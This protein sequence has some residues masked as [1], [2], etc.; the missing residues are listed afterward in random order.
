MAL[1]KYIVFPP[2][3]NFSCLLGE[4][5][6]GVG[7][8]VVKEV[9]ELAT[10]VYEE[11]EN[12]LSDDCGK[13]KAVDNLGVAIPNGTGESVRQDEV[14][15]SKQIV[16]VR[17]KVGEQVERFLELSSEEDLPKKKSKGEESREGNM[18]SDEEEDEETVEQVK[19][20]TSS[21]VHLVSAPVKT[22]FDDAQPE[23]P[24]NSVN[25]RVSVLDSEDNRK[26][27]V[28][29]SNLVSTSK[30]GDRETADDVEPVEEKPEAGLRR[31]LTVEV[32][33]K[34]PP[35]GKERKVRGSGDDINLMQESKKVRSIVT[36][37][38]NKVAGARQGGLLTKAKADPRTRIKR[39]SFSKEGYLTIESE[40]EDSVVQSKNKKHS[41]KVQREE[42]SKEEER[43]PSKPKPRAQPASSKNGEKTKTPVRLKPLRVYSSDDVESEDHETSSRVADQDLESEE[44]LP[45]TIVLPSGS[46]AKTGDIVRTSDKAV[47][48]RRRKSDIEEQVVAVK[49]LS[50]QGREPTVA[51][52]RTISVLSPPSAISRG[53]GKKK[54]HHDADEVVAVHRSGKSKSKTQIP[55]SDSESAD[56][57]NEI[58]IS[59]R[60]SGLTKSKSVKA[61]VGQSSLRDVID[62][63]QKPKQQEKRQRRSY[64]ASEL[65]KVSEV[66]RMES[67]DID[68][69]HNLRSSPTSDSGPDMPPRRR[70]AA[71]NALHRLHDTLMPDLVNFEAQMK[72][73]KGRSRQSAGSLTAFAL[74]FEEERRDV[75][76]RKNAAQIEEGGDA[77]DEEVQPRK[78]RRMS[79]ENENIV[80]VKGKL[81]G[82]QKAKEDSV[83]IEGRK[84]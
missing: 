20:R 44:D 7:N 56:E 37:S 79:D 61:K 21:T 53:K 59:P 80:K 1:E 43:R 63:G 29:S 6:V 28:V 31:K 13:D 16:N 69:D 48:S 58:R 55:V 19:T 57:L 62:S 25:S 52:K 10:V 66:G 15:D 39:K 17:S 64:G 50:K 35:K 75:G 23:K 82:K 8:Q 33:M 45:E 71:A 9:E 46:Q 54:A 47:T 27:T 12:Y 65:R 73:A 68:D 84:T 38:A 83:E 22:R 2:G 18:S 34:S 5:G 76:K 77:S 24:S 49:S 11:D 3:V 60:R 30:K 81:K 40:E 26:G 78:K 67:M 36:P 32:V 51:P 42:V 14:P 4:R 72:K 70:N 41:H 74:D